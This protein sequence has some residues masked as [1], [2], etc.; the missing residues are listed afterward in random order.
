MKRIAEQSFSYFN[1]FFPI[2]LK[3]EAETI[4]FVSA[5]KFTVIFYIN[6]IRL[7]SRRSRFSSAIADFI[8]KVD[9]SRR[10]TDLTEKRHPLDVFFL[11]QAT[12][13]E[14]ARFPTGT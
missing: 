12:G 13:I 3:V 14:P 7:K 11:V 5:F 9:L 8:H 6:E 4:N 2:P 10:K 1:T